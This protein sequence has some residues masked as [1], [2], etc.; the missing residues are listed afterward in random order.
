MKTPL[1]VIDFFCGAGGFSEGFRQ[2]GFKII[3]GYD[4]W[5]PAIKTYNH[6]FHLN[7]KEKNILDFQSIDE[8]NTIPNTDIIIGSPPCVS[9]SSSNHSGKADKSLGL[10]LIQTFLKIVAVK[11]LQ[12]NSQLKAWYMEN[13][14]NSLKYL[15]TAYTLNDLGLEE[16]AIQ[17][18]YSPA[19]IAIEI[20]GNTAIINAADYGAVQARKRMFAG[21]IIN[22]HS[23]II[24]PKTNDP[25]GQN[26]LPRYKSLSLVRQSL[27]SPFSKK[28]DLVI[29]DPQYD[30][31]LKQEQ[32]YDHFYDTGIYQREWELSKYW[33]TNHPFMGRMSFPEDNNKPSRTI[34]AT[35][36]ANSRESIIYKT[37]ITRTGDGEYRLPTVREGAIIMGFPITYQFLGNEGTKWKLVGNAVCCHVS[38][39]FA[40]QTCKELKIRLKKHL[41][42]TPNTEGVENLNSFTLK[43]FKNPPVRKAG[44]RFRRHSIKDGNM[45][46]SLSN[47][48]IVDNGKT[49]GI[50]RT[51]IQY[52]TG[53]GFPSQSIKSGTYIQ[54]KD[55]L[56]EREEFNAFIDFM[57]KLKLRY[58]SAKQLQDAYETHSNNDSDCKDPCILINNLADY[59][60]NHIPDIL[61]IQSDVR[62]FLYKQAVPLRQFYALFFINYISSNAN[63]LNHDKRSSNQENR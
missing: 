48:D 10:K 31:V 5:G 14:P 19:H 9:F 8:I 34:T 11:K 52:G 26:R 17:N 54:I 22:C 30:I 56:K 13:V 4:S 15:K 42:A 33:K 60:N 49:D 28:S 2:A 32:L 24:P 53:K 61:V 3:A 45:T 41:E 40:Q 63:Y 16:W 12:A 29:K 58:I 44:A 47:Y 39:A 51:S 27:P 35:R 55:F 62:F 37:E 36:I 50:W 18:N 23:L 1:T 43:S 20:D 25:K 57:D 38:R 6:N 7:C 46:V 21:E 59:L